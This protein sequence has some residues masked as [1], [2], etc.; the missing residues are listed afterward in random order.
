[1]S[2][3]ALDPTRN[4]LRHDAQVIGLVGL[5]HGVSH[6]YHLL[7]APLFPWIKAEFGLS[8]AELG[9]L[10]TVFFAVSAVVQ[11]ASGFVVDR[12][13]ARPV[14]FAGLAFLGAA[15][16][17]LS[18]S[19][20]YAALLFGA[21]VAGLGNGVF[22]PA[23]FTLLNK[24]VSQPRLGHAFSVHGISGNLG[25]AAAPL[26][27][28]AIA[29]LASWRVALAAASAV[30][31]IVLAVLVL[32]RHVLDPREVQGAVGRPTAKAA[33]GVATSGGSVLGFLRLP[34][35]WV[36]WAFFLLTTFSA[37]GI[38]SFAPTALTYLYGMPFTLATASYTIYMLCSAGGM[39]VGGFAASRTSNHDRLIAVSFTVAGL[40]AVLV[41][42]NLVPALL[43]PVL[44]GVIGFGAGTAG[45]SRDLLVRAAAPAGATGRVYGVVYSGLD[46]GLA[47]GPL[48][49]GA[50]MDAKLPAWVFFMIGG[51]QLLSIFTAVTVGNG[52]RSRRGAAASQAEAA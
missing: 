14:L 23:D 30:A 24:H 12:F 40:M 31:F 13:G 27:L 3:A 28:V 5:A 36:C 9:L 21:A 6:F 4:P 34:Q 47:C 20:G 2:T 51:F 48:F 42:L 52:N 43:V 50:L 10:M 45:P 25:W 8:Y 35:V 33:A 17:L 15:A 39:I 32:L 22:H 49:F 29:N 26:F 1:M 7:L 18:T 41:G 44:M 11:T 37:A 46:I 19:S 16:L 38:Q